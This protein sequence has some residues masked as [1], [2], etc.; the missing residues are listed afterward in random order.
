MAPN[1]AQSGTAGRDVWYTGGDGRLRQSEISFTGNHTQGGCHDVE[2]D[3]GRVGRAGRS[4]VAARGTGTRGG[5][6]Q[7]DDDDGPSD[8]PE[9][10]R[11]STRLNSSHLGISYAVFCLK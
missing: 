4:R 1:I 3:H 10:D 7:R 11:K 8:R 6:R 2:A 5:R 9:L